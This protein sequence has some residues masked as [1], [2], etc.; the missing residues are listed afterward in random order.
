VHVPQRQRGT[1]AAPGAAEAPHEARGRAGAG[2][3]IAASR[4]RLAE[5]P[6]E[7]ARID[8]GIPARPVR[9]GATLTDV[10]AGRT[11]LA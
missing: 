9:R 1:G 4:D 5:R 7:F 8:V 6:A 3:H 11:T 2:A 10:S